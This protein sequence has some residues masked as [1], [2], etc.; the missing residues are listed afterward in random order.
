MHSSH[1]VS[2]LHHAWWAAGAL[3]SRVN[4]LEAARAREPKAHD[5]L[6]SVEAAHEET[7][8]VR[9]QPPP[10]RLTPHPHPKPHT[11]T[12]TVEAAHEETERVRDQ[13]PPSRLTPS[14]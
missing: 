5:L 3:T 12:L 1:C 10:S 8:R 13:P 2:E 14:L 11:L 4:K 7:E 6:A 9:D